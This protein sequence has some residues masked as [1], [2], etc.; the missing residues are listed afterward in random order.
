MVISES[1]RMSRLERNDTRRHPAS[2]G[3]HFEGVRILWSREVITKIGDKTVRANEIVRSV[4]LLGIVLIPI[5]LTAVG[6][7]GSARIGGKV[8]RE[9]IRDLKLQ[10]VAEMLV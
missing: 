3:L 9:C 6:A 5:G 10:A 4:A 2:E 8:A 7:V 1:E